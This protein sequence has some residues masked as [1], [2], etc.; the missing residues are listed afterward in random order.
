MTDA[1]IKAT[2]RILDAAANRAGEGLRTLEEYARFVLDDADRAGQWK[3]IRHQLAEAIARFPRG[4][5]LAARDTQGDVGTE[6]VQPAEYQRACLPDVLAA[7]AARTQQSLRVLEEYGK[8]IDIEAAARI[9]QLRYRCYTASAD[10]ERQARAGHS[11]SAYRRQEVLLGGKLYVL[12]DAG[13][14]EETFVSSVQSLYDGGVDLVQLRDAH[15]DDRTLIARAS[16]GTKIANACHGLFIVNDRADLALAA[17]ADGVHVGQEELPVAVARQILGPQRLIGV[18]THSIEQARQA[19]IAGAD[20]IGCGPIFAGQTKTFKTYVGPA[21]LREV[22]ADPAITIPTFAIGG[23]RRDNIDQ[24]LA[25]G[26][27][28]VA[29]TGAI[30]DAEDPPAAAN[31]LKQILQ[32]ELSPRRVGE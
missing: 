20:Y 10:L 5:L 6:L 29:V 26:C 15:A 12:V 8:T 31:R 21:L 2:Y 22:A 32:G 23:I 24:V 9:E 19:Q 14:D 17:D 1:S 30:G 13:P 7:A 18:S 28:R 3:A 4:E 11:R 25:A 27:D 16:I